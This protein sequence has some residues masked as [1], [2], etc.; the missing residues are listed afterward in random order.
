MMTSLYLTQAE[1]EGYGSLPKAL[2][3]GWTL[4]SE[5]QQFADTPGHFRMR[6]AYLKIRDPKLLVLKEALQ[7]AKGE[8][9]LKRLVAGFDLQG[10]RQADLAELFFALGPAN[11]SNVIAVLLQRAKADEDIAVIAALSHIRH[12]LLGSFI[13][14]Y[15]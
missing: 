2:T 9:D 1:Q 7:K 11:V 5:E 8:E 14:N 4:L 6:L 10:V 12:A 15:R 3:E 13:R